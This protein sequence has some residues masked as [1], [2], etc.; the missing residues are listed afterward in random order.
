MHSAPHTGCLQ[1]TQLG[2]S[3][4]AIPR[5]GREL[6]LSFT[7]DHIISVSYIL[8]LDDSDRCLASFLVTRTFASTPIYF[9]IDAS[10]V[11]LLKSTQLGCTHQSHFRSEKG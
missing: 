10:P 6:Q 9:R 7:N 4:V 3:P 2:A 8:D 1:S 5:I 11:Q